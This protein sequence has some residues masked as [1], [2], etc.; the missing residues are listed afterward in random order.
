MAGAGSGA[1][2]KLYAHQ[3]DLPPLP[4]PTL[5]E[6]LPKFLS[7][8]KPLVT[9]EV[10]HGRRP[11]EPLFDFFV[12]GFLHPAGP[13]PNCWYAP[14]ICPTPPSPSRPLRSMITL[15][16]LSRHS[17]REW[18]PSCRSCWRSEG[19]LSGTG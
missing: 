14:P 8:V 3:D 15:C 10:G 7:T 9:P 6:T 11:R 18:G 1:K 16:Q 12:F 5:E 17:S 2:G 4:V 19:R 13:H